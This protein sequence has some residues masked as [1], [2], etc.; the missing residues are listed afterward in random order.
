M[1]I[2][3]VREIRECIGLRRPQLIV[4][5]EP[6]SFT[7]PRKWMNLNGPTDYN[8]VEQDEKT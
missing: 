7:I 5:A 2:A 8:K 6:Y 1:S 3:Q 4:Q